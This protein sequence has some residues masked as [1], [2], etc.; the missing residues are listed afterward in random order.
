MNVEL[1][2]FRI[3]KYYEE[4]FDFSEYRYNVKSIVL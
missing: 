1:D 4:Y 2:F 3:L